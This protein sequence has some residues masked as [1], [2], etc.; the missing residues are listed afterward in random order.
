[1]IRIA[2]LIAAALI[3]AVALAYLGFTP[4]RAEG[5]VA[6]A[7]S[8]LPP[9]Y[10][11]WRLITVAHEEGKQN[12][13]R[14]ILGND[15]AYKAARDGKL[16]YPD[17][18]IIVRLAWSYVSSE[19]NNKAFGGAQSFIAGAPTNVQFMVKDSSK[20][21]STGGWSYVQFN[22]GKLGDPAGFGACFACHVPVKTRDYVFNR[23]SP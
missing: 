10:R 7:L 8:S 6:P 17:G 5:G 1:M 2:Q 12:D 3:F 11:D 18:A 23:Y 22:D 21:A 20:Y 19:E 13:I 9:G 14:A 15:I 16:P 4:A